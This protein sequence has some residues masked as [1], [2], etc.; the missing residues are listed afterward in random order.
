MP[1]LTSILSFIVNNGSHPTMKVR[2]KKAII[3]INIF[4]VISVIGW[5]FFFIGLYPSTHSHHTKF[6]AVYLTT[7]AGFI[8]TGLLVRYKQRHTAKVV[9]LSVAY[10]GVFFFDN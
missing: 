7:T 3:L 1:L 9:L 4:W 6:L 8:L 5:F 10:A 2:Q